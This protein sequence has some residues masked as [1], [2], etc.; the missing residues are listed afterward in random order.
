M[1]YTDDV[2][3]ERIGVGQIINVTG[4]V[5][6]H[7][8]DTSSTK[9]P[10]EGAFYPVYK[11]HKTG[12]M[13]RGTKYAKRNDRDT[14]WTDVLTG[15][16]IKYGNLFTKSTSKGRHLKESVNKRACWLENVEWKM[17]GHD[18]NCECVTSD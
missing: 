4:G 3:E 2:D 5:T 1:T 11:N 10:I 18:G 13:Y 8:W 9:N 6:I 14:L 17:K 7:W 16:L 15:N 12:K